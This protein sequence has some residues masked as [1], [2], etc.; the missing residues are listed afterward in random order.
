[1]TQVY[2][3]GLF[4]GLAFSCLAMLKRKHLVYAALLAAAA[5]LT[6]A[7]GVALVIPMALAW[8]NT[9]EWY[10]LDV[11]W[12]QLLYHR[13]PWR[14]IWHALLAFTPV[15]VFLIWRF[16]FY[17]SA[18]HFVE[19]IYFGRAT[20]DIVYSVGAWGQSF[21]EMVAGILN[22]KGPPDLPLYINPAHSA[23]YLSEFL[24][25]AVGLV[26]IMRCLKTDPIVASFSLAVFV[27]SWGSGLPQGITRYMLSA[28]AVFITLA[29]WGKNQVFDRTWTLISILLMGLL[30]MLF[31]Y[32]FWV[33]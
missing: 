30:A 22:I 26:A 23:A 5:T 21:I 25:M 3:E 18:F 20:L 32:N 4:V 29:H 7:V 16:S 15:I 9:K 2:T 28:P 13:P 33:P 1:M 11:E 8:I 19:T 6:R 27:I 17:G 10:S 24:G 31:A 14:P 12:L